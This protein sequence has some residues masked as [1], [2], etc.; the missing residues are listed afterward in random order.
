MT[1]L[2]A[3]HILAMALLHYYPPVYEPGCL[4]V[5][6]FDWS[7]PELDVSGWSNG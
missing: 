7:T 5:R 1:D 2:V 4:S 3:Q 6:L